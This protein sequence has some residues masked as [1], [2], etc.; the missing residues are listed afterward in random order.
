MTLI[1][2]ILLLFFAIIFALI[3]GFW[4]VYNFWPDPNELQQTSILLGQDPSFEFIPNFVVAS[5]D[6]WTFRISMIYVYSLICVSYLITIFCNYKV[7]HH[8]KNMTNQMTIKTKD[9]QTQF[10]I[11]QIIQATIPIINCLIPIGVLVTACFLYS[12]TSL[13]GL[14][15]SIVLS[16]MPICNPLS[17]MLVIKNYRKS[18]IIFFKNC[19]HFKKQRISTAVVNTNNQL[20]RASVILPNSFANVLYANNSNN[21][22]TM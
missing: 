12:N 2:Y 6:G 8:L 1:R 14:F 4:T 13:S 15:A 11:T 22:D 19:W 16:T 10:T 5:I 9:A 17:T 21:I 7:W 20:S 3:E 18:I